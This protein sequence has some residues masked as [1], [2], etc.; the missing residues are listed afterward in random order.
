MYF[1]RVHES[2]LKAGFK[3]K[4]TKKVLTHKTL[5]LLMIKYVESGTKKTALIND[6]KQKHESD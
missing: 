1:R 3:K 2:S 4:K 5:K 6:K